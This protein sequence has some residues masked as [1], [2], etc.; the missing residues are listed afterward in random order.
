MGVRQSGAPVREVD[1]EKM[2][3]KAAY[4][5]LLAFMAFDAHCPCCDQAETCEDGCTFSEDCPGDYNDM[6][7]AREVIAQAKAAK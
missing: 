1:E 5:I 7:V 6:V 2:N 4:E 3:Y